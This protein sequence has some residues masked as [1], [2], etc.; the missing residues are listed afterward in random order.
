MKKIITLCILSIVLMAAC[1]RNSGNSST[2]SSSVELKV[3]TIKAN[4]PSVE[5]L[6]QQWNVTNKRIVVLFG[7]D[8]NSEE[9]VKSLTQK[10]EQR[11]GLDSD[12]GLIISYIYPDSFKHNGKTFPS[13][14]PAL[15]DEN[16]KEIAGIVLLGAPAGTETALS[17]IQYFWKLEVPY[18]IIA[19]FSQEE[20]AG[21]EANCDIVIDKA[22]KAE[23]TGGI[24]PE[25]TITEMSEDAPEILLD[26]IDYI[27]SLN[28]AIP[29]DLKKNEIKD[30]VKLMLRNREFTQY[31]D[32]ESGLTSINHF[33]LH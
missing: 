30:H 11:Y 4:K 20:A 32:P 9:T 27:L 5:Q 2:S 7:Y 25:E 33:V 1:N 18:P 16:E 15:I 6:I 21:L 31:K 14:F 3:D 22:Q 13:E 19:L 8:F 24:A 17:R 26:T 12:G 23:I 28:G 29:K 10:L